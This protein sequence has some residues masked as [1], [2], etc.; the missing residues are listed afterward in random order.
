MEKLS[1]IFVAVFTTKILASIVCFLAGVLLMKSL[2][3]YYDFSWISAL[4][5]Q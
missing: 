2:S 5:A 1:K 3:N 4:A